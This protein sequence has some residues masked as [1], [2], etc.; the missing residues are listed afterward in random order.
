MYIS[1]IRLSNIRCIEDLEIRLHSRSRT[2]DSLLLL[3]NNA[4]GKSTILRSIAI[5]LCDWVGASG[6]VADMYG[7]LI[8]NGHSQ[9][10]IEVDLKDGRREHKTVT[11][12]LVSDDDPSLEQLRREASPGFP[13]SELFVCG[14]GPTRALQG[15]NTYSQYAAADAV[16]P[17]FVY[18]SQ[19]QN[20][21]LVVR[22]RGAKTEKELLR[23][24]S[25]L[26][27][28]APNAMGMTRKGLTLQNRGGGDSTLGALADGHRSTLNWILDLI[29][30]TLLTGR[31]DPR[32]IVLIDEI[33]NHLHPTWQR[34]IFRLL[35]Q[36]FPLVQFIAT[37]HSPLPAG[38]I[39]ERRGSRLRARRGTRI[40]KAHVLRADETG[41]VIS[42]ELPALYG[43]TYDQILESSAFDTPSRPVVL[44]QAVQAVLDVYSGPRSR[45]TTAFKDAMER[46][47]DVSPMEA[48][49]IGER[50][51][52][53]EL[54]S[55]FKALLEQ[56]GKPSA[57]PD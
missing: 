40:G 8:K 45:D 38:S 56:R 50:H 28:M 35:S 55:A 51:V 49:S 26:L 15:T 32:G 16:Y 9:G 57:S 39:Y 2:N 31:E 10:R 47:R 25:K 3:G 42:E 21:E 1:R 41:R 13:W 4:V 34:H 19:L 29:G 30:W 18:G 43:S 17:L 24:L 20:P 23:R 36:Q 7:N 12:I 22:R 44:E 54:D 5:A 52:A 48:A 11:N 53:D 37:S 6:L 14:Y 27:M 46:L 33:E